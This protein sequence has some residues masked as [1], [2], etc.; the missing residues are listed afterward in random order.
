MAT[1]TFTELSTSQAVSITGSIIY[2]TDYYVKRLNQFSLEISD[3][4]DVVYDA[5]PN[6]VIGTLMMKGISYQEGL[7]FEDWLENNLIFQKNLFSIGGIQGVNLGNGLNT[8]ISGARYTGGRTTEGVLKPVAP[9][10]F[11]LN[12]PYKFKKT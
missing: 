2:G 7:D 5:G 10:T 11:N 6:I 4:N 1:V 12:F 9:G 3:G 8:G